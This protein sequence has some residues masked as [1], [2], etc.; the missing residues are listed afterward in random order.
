MHPPAAVLTATRQIRRPNT[1]AMRPPRSFTATLVICSLLPAGL[2]AQQ[3][4]KHR[5]L[6]ADESRGQLIYV[7]QFDPTQ[8]WTLKTPEKHR[9]MQLIGGGKLLVNTDSGYREYD[10]KTQKETK[11]V[12]QALLRGSTSAQRLADG[13]TIL[14]CNQNNG[15]TFHVL[16]AADQPA[17]R[18]LE[19]A[20]SWSATGPVTVPRTATKRR[21]SSSLTR[22]ARLPGNGTTRNAPARFTKSSCS[23][24]WIPAC[25]I[26]IHPRC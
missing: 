7:N 8:D 10:L 6:A 3:P 19:T 11:H 24:N 12:N 15:I 17:S 23:M 2:L 22:L 4:I 25:S 20:T 14:G 21:N 5:F 18:C 26:Q 16:D 13:R 9:D 1:H